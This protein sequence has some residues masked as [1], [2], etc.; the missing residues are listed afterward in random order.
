MHGGFLVLLP[1]LE[2]ISVY[3]KGITYLAHHYV[4]YIVYRLW[5]MV[6]S[7]AGWQYPCA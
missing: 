5:S 3:A 1:S 4:H 6:K 2:Q 7:W